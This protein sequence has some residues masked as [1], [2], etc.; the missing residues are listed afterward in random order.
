MQTLLEICP[1][2][3]QAW[4][5]WEKAWAER[6]RQEQIEQ[7]EERHEPTRSYSLSRMS[8]QQ[9]VEVLDDG[10]FRLSSPRKPFSNRRR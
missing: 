1:S 5:L 8:D 10:S 4:C 3:L 2:L 6:L 7:D 9:D